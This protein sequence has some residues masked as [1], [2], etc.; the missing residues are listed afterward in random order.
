VTGVNHD[1]TSDEALAR[2]ARA[3]SLASFEELVRRY[4]VPLLRF[5]QR[6][7]PRPEDAEDI[8]QDTFLRAYSALN[9]YNEGYAFKTWLFTIAYR[10]AVSSARAS[11]PKM[12][13]IDASV[14]NHQDEPDQPA[15]RRESHERLW[16]L[17]RRTLNDEQYAALWLHYVEDTAPRDIA[18]VLGRSWVWVRTALHR[19]QRKLA[20][21]I[22]AEAPVAAALK[23][24]VRR[25]R[26]K[27]REKAIAEGD[28]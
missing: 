5:L 13:L 7:S 25:Y 17:A 16:D 22:L 23:L 19:S 3:G 2:Q 6:R 18:A 10:L 20:D 12:T 4:Q 9:K 28:V 1:R 11:R 14:A 27:A 15:M 26:E 21:A 24:P 8:M